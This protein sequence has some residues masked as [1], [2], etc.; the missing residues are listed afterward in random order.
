[1]WASVD[2]LRAN[3][4]N[5]V[6]ARR[7]ASAHEAAETQLE[8]ARAIAD[9]ET[10]PVASRRVGLTQGEAVGLMRELAE[11]GV[12]VREVRAGR[13]ACTMATEVAA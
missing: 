1:M 8:L 13:A 9:G 7:F 11:R 10:L 2:W 6:A 3:P 5:A 4:D 12:L